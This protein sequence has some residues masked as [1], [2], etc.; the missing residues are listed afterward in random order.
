[1]VAKPS[2][3]SKFNGV[4]D[5]AAKTAMI[6]ELAKTGKEAKLKGF[7][8]V[9]SLHLVE[10][11]FTVEND[12][13]TPSMKLKRPQLQKAYQKELDAMYVSLKKK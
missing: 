12:L 9:K 10:E 3:L 4:A 8:M 5:P 1:M 2:F 7:E 11:H 13:M 6:E